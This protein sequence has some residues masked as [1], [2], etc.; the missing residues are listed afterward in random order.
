MVR[1]E[2]WLARVGERVRPVVVL[3]RQE[4]IG[5]RDRVTVAEI[6]TS[7]RGLKAEVPFQAESAGLDRDSVVNGD[8]LYT[9]HRSALTQRIGSLDDTTMRQTCDAIRYALGC[10]TSDVLG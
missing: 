2:I 6:T 5:Y 4:V 1:S 8:G 3:T 7:I 10:S 9:V